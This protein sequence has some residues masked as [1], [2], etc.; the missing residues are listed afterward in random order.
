MTGLL[1]SLIIEYLPGLIVPTYFVK[2]LSAGNNVFVKPNGKPFNS[3]F[4]ELKQ[5]ISINLS[6]DKQ[7]AIDELVNTF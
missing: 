1:I 6:P 2:L 4:K 3:S 7:R 5:T